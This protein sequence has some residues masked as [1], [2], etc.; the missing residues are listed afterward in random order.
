[1]KYNELQAKYIGTLER[2]NQFL[3]KELERSRAFSQ[4]ESKC[5]SARKISS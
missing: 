4:V 2:T 1:M 5:R 3:E